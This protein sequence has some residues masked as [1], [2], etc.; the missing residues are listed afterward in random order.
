MINVWNEIRRR[1]V[2][3]VCSIPSMKITLFISFIELIMVTIYNLSLKIV[4]MKDYVF[5]FLSPF[6]F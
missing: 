1:L 5:F 4:L 6:Y 2:F 3:Y